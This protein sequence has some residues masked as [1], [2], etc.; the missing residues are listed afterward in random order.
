MKR[1]D[2][3]YSE[4]HLRK[5]Q[6]VAQPLLLIL[7]IV[8]QFLL[9]SSSFRA[10]M[11]ATKVEFTQLYLYQEKHPQTLRILVSPVIEKPKAVWPMKQ[12]P[13]FPPLLEISMVGA[14]SLPQEHLTPSYTQF[15]SVY[16][17][18]RQA[19]QPAKGIKSPIPQQ[20]GSE[21]LGTLPSTRFPCLCFP[22]VHNSWMSWG[23]IVNKYCLVY[24]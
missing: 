5:T 18:A 19:E 8:C 6:R 16:P 23:G 2:T 12:E 10:P 7:A 4:L 11:M 15:A 1:R 14:S 22:L 20:R 21:A 17:F 9:F 24:T 13:Y 3:S